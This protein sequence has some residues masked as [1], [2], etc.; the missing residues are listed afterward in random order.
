MFAV[1]WFTL[2]HRRIRPL[3]RLDLMRDSTQ[4][5]AGSRWLG[6]VGKAAC[7]VILE[8][9]NFAA[10]ILDTQDLSTIRGGS[11]LLRDLVPK[12][13]AALERHFP[14]K[15]R[16]A[17]AGGSLGIWQVAAD[18]GAVA[19]AL[20]KIRAE[21]TAGPARHLGFGLA[22]VVDDGTGYARQ[23]LRL[24]AALQRARLAEV[25]VPYPDLTDTEPMVCQVDFVRP[26]GKGKRQRIDREEAGERAVLKLSTSVYDRRRFGIDKKQALIAEETDPKKLSHAAQKA[27]ARAGRAFA[28]QMGS[29]SEQAAP[30]EGLKQSLQ[31]KVCVITLDGNGFGAIQDAALAKSD[32]IEAQIMFDQALAGMRSELIAQVFSQVI[33]AGGEGVPCAEE[34]AVRRE[35]KDPIRDGAPVIRF[36]LL[37]WG[38]DEIMFVVPAR[39]G[40]Q[41]LESIGTAAARLR[42]LEKP[43]SFSVGAVFCHHDAPIVRVKALADG[44]CGHI[45]RLK[46]DTGGGR[47]GKAATLFMI[48][49]LESFDHVGMDLAA[50]LARRLP[51]PMGEKLSPGAEG[52]FAVLDCAELAALR[53]SAEAL[54]AG[55]GGTVSR[56]RLR[57]TA[58]ALH[59][60]AVPGA[61]FVGPKWVDYVHDSTKRL[62]GK[63]VELAATVF[64]V[65]HG[66]GAP[67]GAA[68]SADD[69]GQARFFTLLDAY[70]DYLTPIR[71]KAEATERGGR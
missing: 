39:I 44:L 3:Q 57:Q 26:V 60:G 34:E 67:K 10:S 13:G 62:R 5:W 6:D 43:V 40:W 36:E 47:D 2:P 37:L 71:Q 21:L 55:T 70:W 66:E 56:G 7:W 64:H 38:G 69:I 50:H 11:L 14:G 45:K 15:V 23:R 24:R 29:I 32:T 65:H 42:V 4:A 33:D 20:E 1:D 49:V 9:Q 61:E 58:F 28:M 63:A 48:E 19:P 51:K 41:V 18:Q 27:L 12:A 59:R 54:A 46:P 52:A 22:A 30:P 35:L 53:L 16:C 68:I 17:T 25:R 31:D 8:G